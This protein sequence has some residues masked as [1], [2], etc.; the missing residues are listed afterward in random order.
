MLSL[1]ASWQLFAQP[2]KVSN[3][4]SEKLK[5]LVLDEANKVAKESQTQNK[6][7][8]GDSYTNFMTEYKNK[9]KKLEKHYGSASLELGIE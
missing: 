2:F 5:F 4:P 1:K 9:V 7:S 3:G 8:Q 6:E